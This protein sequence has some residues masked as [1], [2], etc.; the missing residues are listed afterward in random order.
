[1]RGIYDLRLPGTIWISQKGS[2]QK[3]NRVT[4]NS[5]AVFSCV[6]DTRTDSHYSLNII[7]LSIAKFVSIKSS[8]SNI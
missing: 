6:Y 4:G 3:L 2:D 1:M 8:I 7:T 5:P